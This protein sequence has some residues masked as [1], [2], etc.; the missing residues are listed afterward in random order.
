M[1]HSSAISGAVTNFAPWY[2]P[3]HGVPLSE[4]PSSL[5]CPSGHVFEVRRGISRFVGSSGYAATFGLQWNRFRRTQLDSVSGLTLSTDRLRRCLGPTAWDSLEGS[6]VLEG[7]CGAGRFTEVLLERG[8]TVTSIDLSEAV[9]ANHENFSHSPRHRVAQANLTR[10]PFAPESF[11]VVVCL[12][13]LQHTP[14]P[15]GTIASLCQVL[16]PGGWLVLDHYTYK[17]GWFLSLRPAARQYFLRRSPETA[18]CQIARV[19]EC[20]LPLQR[21]VARRPVRR[22]LLNALVPVVSFYGSLPE[23]S[24]ELQSQWALL[25]TYDSLTDRF[26][27]FRT[28]GQIERAVRR[29]G[30]QDVTCRHGGNGIELRARRSLGSRQPRLKAL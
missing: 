4:E 25:D 17:L 24:T 5:V 6:Q 1:M 2:C 12:G 15:E 18:M 20:A 7:G 26:K 14:S 11:D 8:A 30:L 9:V 3:D 28:R 23:L 19:V 29:L 27:H 13:V 21:R 10:L 16:R 22:R